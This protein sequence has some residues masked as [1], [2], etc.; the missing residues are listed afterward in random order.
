MREFIEQPSPAHMLTTDQI[1]LC[2][3]RRHIDLQRVASALC[4]QP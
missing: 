2:Y 3:S 4:S 1:V